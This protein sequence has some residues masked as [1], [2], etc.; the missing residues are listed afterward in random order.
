MPDKFELTPF[1]RAAINKTLHTARMT[2]CESVQ[3]MISVLIDLRAMIDDSQIEPRSTM[4]NDKMIA[5]MEKEE[6]DIMTTL[7][8]IADLMESQGVSA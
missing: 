6:R 3:E 7:V 2:L 4:Y 5:D 1:E 8:S